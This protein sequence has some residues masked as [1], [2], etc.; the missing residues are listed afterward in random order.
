VPH[1]SLSTLCNMT[2]N[3]AVKMHSLHSLTSTGLFWSRQDRTSFHSLLDDNGA[4]YDEYWHGMLMPS[5][6]VNSRHLLFHKQSV[7]SQSVDT[8]RS[9]NL[10]CHYYMAVCNFMWHNSIHGYAQLNFNK[11]EL[12]WTTLCKKC[13]NFDN[14]RLILIILG[15]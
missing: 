1:I 10:D 12:I 13:A 11:C 7:T 2:Y 3:T 6:T 14:H 8:T 9:S 4:M 15:K 5:S